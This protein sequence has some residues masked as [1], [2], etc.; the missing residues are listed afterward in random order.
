MPKLF[1]R[2]FETY[3]A[4]RERLVS[5]HKGKTVAIRGDEILGVFDDDLKAL[6]AVEK[7][8]PVG[9]FLLKQVKEEEETATIVTPG[10]VPS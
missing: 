1:P 2:E 4:N 8:H 10:V 5:Q 3:E 7:H 9:T 6:T